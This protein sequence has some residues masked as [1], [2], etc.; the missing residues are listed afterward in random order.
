MKL[1]SRRRARFSLKTEIN[2]KQATEINVS[3]KL[4]LNVRLI[5]CY[6][7]MLAE[8]NQRIAMSNFLIKHSSNLRRN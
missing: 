4:L 3:T 1:K 8:K 6:G 2:N 5:F 7:L